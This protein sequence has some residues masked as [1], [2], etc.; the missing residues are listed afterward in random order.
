M[1]ASLTHLLQPKSVQPKLLQ[2]KIF[3]TQNFATQIFATQN[4]GNPS[5]IYL[6][7]CNF[8]QSD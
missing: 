4:F 7:K 2:P 1:Q 3:S 8:L 5:K 6:Q